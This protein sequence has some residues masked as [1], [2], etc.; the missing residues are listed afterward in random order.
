M[1]FTIG[2]RFGN[3]RTGIYELFGL[4]NA[5]IRIGF[6]YG[7]NQ[8][9]G[10]GI[11]RSTFEKTYDL[12]GKVRLIEQVQ[13][14]SPLSLTWYVAGSQ[15]TIRDRY[16]SDRDNFTGRLS[17]IQNLMVGRMFSEILSM[18]ISAIWLLPEYLTETGESASKLSL[19]IAT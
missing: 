17:V 3:V 9:L 5:T 10:V 13:N 12:Y 15:A 1:I 11:G 7:I 2:H 14:D 6:D 16:P 19:G 18:Q 8:W 4:D